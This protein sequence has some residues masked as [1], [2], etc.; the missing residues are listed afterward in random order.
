MTTTKHS[1]LRRSLAVL[2][3]VMMVMSMGVAN[4]FA[5]EPTVYDEL[6]ALLDEIDSLDESEYVQSGY[7]ALM[8]LANSVNRPVRPPESENDQGGMPENIAELFL[9]M[10]QQQMNKLVLLDSAWGKLETLLD[11]IFALKSEDYVASGYNTL[12]EQAKT[13]NRPIDPEEMPENMATLM[14][15]KLKEAKDALVAA[16]SA[17]GRLEALLD[18]IFALNP[19]DYTEESY[20]ALMEQANSVNRPVDPEIMPENIAELMIT[21]L[22][23]AVD[24]LEPAGDVFAKLEEK[25]QE[26]EKLNPSDY[27]EESWKEVQ[28][29]IAAIDRPVSSDN[30]TEKLAAKMLADLEAAINA[31]EPA[32][33]IRKKIENFAAADSLFIPFRKIPS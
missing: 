9:G 29:I 8:E 23:G 10:L 7:D 17:W 24:D 13:V 26:A 4:V 12:M 22:Q 30:I 14:Y 2:L 15:D 21:M 11:E 16:D 19:D 33:D 28:D 31:L 25:L 27:T 3:A 6:N 32:K 1:W 5:A 18:E 20:N